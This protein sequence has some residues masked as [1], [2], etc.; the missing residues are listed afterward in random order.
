MEKVSVYIPCYNVEK[1]IARCI[2]GILNQTYPVDEILVIDDGSRDRT[3]EIASKYPVQI[4][5]HEVNKGLS[6][7][8]N[9][10]L[11]NAR[12]ELVAALDADCVADSRWL[13][14]LVQLIEEDQKIAVVG[15]RLVES[16][17][18]SVADRWRKVHM[19]QD[20]GDNRVTNPQFMYGNNSLI[21][22]SIVEEVGYYNENFRTN[23][24]DMDITRRIYEKGYQTIYEPNAIVNHLRQDS[25]ASILDTYWRYWR[26][27]A[28]LYFNEI[29]LKSVLYMSYY[30]NFKT[31]FLSVL[32]RDLKMKKY[33]LIWLD[34]VMLMYIT[35][36]S[37]KLLWEHKYLG[38]KLV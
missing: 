17:Q 30:M 38:K 6:A 37:F 16:V 7:A 8:R 15:G 36:R 20:W 11:R 9:T 3:I 12:N 10:G 35:Y 14:N 24:E 1:F 23:G 31:I 25:I 2:E 29:S 34:G 28:N 18:Q 22:K 33:G 21:R 4:I 32:E 5:K 27:G 19:T 26:F 13:E